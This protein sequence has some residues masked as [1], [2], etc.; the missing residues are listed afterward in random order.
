[1][2]RREPAR[3]AVNNRP[4]R[5]TPYTA[6]DRKEL[7]GGVKVLCRYGASLNF[8]PAKIKERLA[9]GFCQLMW[10][11]RKCLFCCPYHLSEFSLII[12]VLM[13][14][15]QAIVQI[16][17][18]PFFHSADATKKLKHPCYLWVIL[19]EWGLTA[20]IRWDDR[21]EE[22]TILHLNDIEVRDKV[23][24]LT[25]PCSLLETKCLKKQILS[26]LPQISMH[27]IL[28]LIDPV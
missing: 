11:P 6:D 28:Q 18:C 1:M 8:F 13:I 23:F 27:V 21:D 16:C 7:F 22:N 5:A 19:L 17:L 4:A 9:D 24:Q 20:G 10:V 14:V 3:A 12:H 2:N 25:Q 15:H 26:I